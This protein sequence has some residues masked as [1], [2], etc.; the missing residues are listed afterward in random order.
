M[1]FLISLTKAL[2]DGLTYRSWTNR[3]IIW[4]RLKHI[5]GVLLILA[6][7]I[8]FSIYGHYYSIFDLKQI[9]ILFLAFACLNFFWFNFMY[10]IISGEKQL[11]GDTDPI[12]LLIASV[13]SGIILLYTKIAKKDPEIP[14]WG[15]LLFIKLYFL[16]LGLYLLD[17]YVAI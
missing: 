12:D 5:A 3:N 4:G 10:R 8:S 6:T 14:I 17:R 13:Y 2:Q 16:S 15:I 1:F 9:V 7:A 11:I